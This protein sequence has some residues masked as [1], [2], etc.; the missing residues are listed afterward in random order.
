MIYESGGSEGHVWTGAELP[1]LEGFQFPL[2]LSPSAPAVFSAG[3]TR[4]G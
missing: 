1:A 3:E 4:E 2:P